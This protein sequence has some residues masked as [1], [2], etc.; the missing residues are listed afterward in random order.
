MTK[1]PWIIFGIHLWQ[2]ALIGGVG[3]IIGIPLG[4]WMAR[5]LT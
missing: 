4:V 5:R 2:Y 3:L 1:L